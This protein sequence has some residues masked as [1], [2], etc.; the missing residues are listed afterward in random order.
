[1]VAAEQQTLHSEKPENEPISEYVIGDTV[2]TK[3]SLNPDQLWLIA[4]LAKD[5][6]S[7][8]EMDAIPVDSEGNPLGGDT[9]TI[10][11]DDI[12]EKT[13][14]PQKTQEEVLAIA[15]I[16]FEAKYGNTIPH[17]EVIAMFERQFESKS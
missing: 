1:M 4:S 14:S 2:R 16:A 12:V 7:G 3:G 17:D 8:A 5:T 10:S 11:V 13:A 15:A 6:P 9:G